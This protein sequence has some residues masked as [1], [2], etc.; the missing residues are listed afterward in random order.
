MRFTLE[1]FSGEARQ[2]ESLRGAAQMTSYKDG[3]SA[4][5][6]DGHFDVMSVCLR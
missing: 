3:F 5:S 6:E 4:N 2:E 1:P